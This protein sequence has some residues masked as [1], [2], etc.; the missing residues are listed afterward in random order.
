MELYSEL[1]E[2][3]TEPSPEKI[4]DS[5]FTKVRTL[6]E[7]SKELAGPEAGEIFTPTVGPKTVTLVFQTEKLNID[8][9]EE[10]EYAYPN[11]FIFSFAPNSFD[12]SYLE[13]VPSRQQN[14]RIEP[15]EYGEDTKKFKSEMSS[16]LDKLQACLDYFKVEV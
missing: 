14:I 2:S 13:A 8:F 12:L 3:F 6:F 1:E 5:L 11:I 7:N 9:P 10:K 4:Y 15:K 16:L